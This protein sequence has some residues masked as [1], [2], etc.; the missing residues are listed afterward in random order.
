MIGRVG[1]PGAV[2]RPRRF[3]VVIAVGR[4]AV[5]GATVSVHDPNST[6]SG[7]V[8]RV[9]DAGSIGRPRRLTLV[10]TVRRQS[11]P[12][13]SCEV[14]GIELALG[15]RVPVGPED[16]L[17]DCSPAQPHR[18]SEA[19]WPLR[20]RPQ[21]AQWTEPATSA[22]RPLPGLGSTTLSRRPMD[23]SMPEDECPASWSVGAIVERCLLGRYSTE[24]PI[25]LPCTHAVCHLHRER[26][27]RC[28]P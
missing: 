14:P 12:R 3:G 2:R 20:R 22:W 10:G 15:V 13:A 7:D 28:H 4:D 25:S 17:T 18:R 6:W 26:R 16:D 21:R 5:L 11:L 1:D 8:R 24:P 19:P 9:R 23:V 27:D